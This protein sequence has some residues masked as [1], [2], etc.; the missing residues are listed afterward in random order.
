MIS[1]TN[2]TYGQLE[3]TLRSLGFSRR[4][5]ERNGNKGIRYEHKETGALILLPHFPDDDRVLDY[6]L[7]EVRTTVDGFGV[8]DPSVFEAKLQ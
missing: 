3:K 1:R 5:F 8:A 4:V 2:I 6:H 7:A